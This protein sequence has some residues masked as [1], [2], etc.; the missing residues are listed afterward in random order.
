[1]ALS[2]GLSAVNTPAAREALRL[3]SGWCTQGPTQTVTVRKNN[4]KVIYNKSTC[5]FG[6]TKLKDIMVQLFVMN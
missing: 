1:M 2:C 3:G 5:I 4:R 6:M